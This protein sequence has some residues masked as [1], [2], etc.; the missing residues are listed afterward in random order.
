MYIPYTLDK[1]SK[2]LDTVFS[3]GNCLFGAVKLTKNTDPDKHKYS[4]Y[5]IGFDSSSLRSWS[6]GSY[7]KNAIIFGVDDSFSVHIVDKNKNILA[8]GEGLTQGLEDATIR[9]E[10]R[11]HIDFT[12]SGKRFL[13]SLHYNGSNSFLLVNKVKKYQFNIS[14][15]AKD[16]EIKPHT[17]CLGNISKYFRFNNIKKKNSIKGDVWAFFVDYDHINSS[18]IL[19]IHRFLKKET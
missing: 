18:N 19:D 9:A 8:L 10:A 3:L 12:E 11:H 15:K 14:N 17:L 4:G 2:D 1:W 16:S 13:L 7:G 6:D 5:G